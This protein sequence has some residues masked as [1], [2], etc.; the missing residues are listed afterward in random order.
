MNR[1][2][3][4]SDGAFE[5]GVRGCQRKEIKRIDYDQFFYSESLTCL[6]SLLINFFWVHVYT[7]LITSQ[8]A[9]TV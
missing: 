1:F 3:Y 9:D 5:F 7:I 6:V 2:K 4:P 8:R